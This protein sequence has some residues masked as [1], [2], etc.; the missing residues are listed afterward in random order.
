MN[1]VLLIAGAGAL[2]SVCRYG[3]AF[4]GQR[5]SGS[6]FPVGT[7]MVNM[8]GCLCI[9]FLGYL[10]TGL[11]LIREE[12]RLAIFVGF[13]GAFTTFSTFGWETFSLLNA[14]QKGAALANL[15]LSNLIGLAAVWAGYRIAE[16]IY[17]G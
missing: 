13:L 4:W 1:K 15:L 9:G 16:S 17:G 14:G 12:Y 2:G 5:L 10:F 8:A 7:L 11:Y 6:M 3:L